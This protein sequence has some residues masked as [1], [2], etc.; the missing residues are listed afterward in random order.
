MPKQQH[1]AIGKDLKELF[2]NDVRET[3]RIQNVL[4]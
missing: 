4:V 3:R 1:V 2:D